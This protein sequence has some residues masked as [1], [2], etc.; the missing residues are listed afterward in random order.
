MGLAYEEEVVKL[1]KK[2]AKRLRHKLEDARMILDRLNYDV[3]MR[4]SSAR[5]LDEVHRLISLVELE[6]GGVNGKRR[7]ERRVE[8][9]RGQGSPES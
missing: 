6:L 8:E 7:H 4:E 5:Q 2:R 1:A 9:T 3:F